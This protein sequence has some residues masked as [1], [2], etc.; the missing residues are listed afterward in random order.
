M[1]WTMILGG[2]AVIA[3]SIA[4]VMA[5]NSQADGLRV[6][7]EANSRM[8]DSEK[9]MLKDW[10]QMTPACTAGVLL[11]GLL[12]ALPYFA[13]AQLFKRDTPEH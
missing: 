8:N 10:F 13:L 4:V 9:M 7:I 3:L 12:A 2:V 5:L 11:A 6:I 1:R